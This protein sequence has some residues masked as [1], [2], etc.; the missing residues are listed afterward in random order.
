MSWISLLVA[1]DGGFAGLAAH[2]GFLGLFLAALLGL[3]NAGVVGAGDLED[4]LSV[5]LLS[6]HAPRVP[7]RPAAAPLTGFLNTPHA[8]PPQKF[9]PCRHHAS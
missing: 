3:V 5:Q 6:D 9:P 4:D 8:S 1:S 7:L 2:W